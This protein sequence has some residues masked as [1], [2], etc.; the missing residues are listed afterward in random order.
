MCTTVYIYGRV[1]IYIYIYI[2][3][4]LPRRKRH[5]V[6]KQ[7]MPTR[8]A[9]FG[10][11]FFQIPIKIEKILE[12]LVCRLGMPT[13]Y[14]DWGGVFCPLPLRIEWRAAIYIYIYI[15]ISE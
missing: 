13:G 12:I 5:A 4:L 9:D 6:R 2:Y 11:V 3:M 7:G 14:A 8:Y 10:R 1:P 15:Y